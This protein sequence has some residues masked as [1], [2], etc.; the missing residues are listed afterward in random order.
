MELANQSRFL[1][2][3]EANWKFTCPTDGCMAPPPGG[4]VTAWEIVEEAE[5]TGFEQSRGLSAW[6]IKARVRPEG[7][8]V[9]RERTGIAAL[10]AEH[11]GDYHTD[12]EIEEM[13]RTSLYFDKLEGTL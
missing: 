6:K 9:S 12:A 2:L 5:T 10:C 4:R 7:D 11:I 3:T 13:L 1:R 8:F